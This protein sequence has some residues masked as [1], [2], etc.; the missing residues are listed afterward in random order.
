LSQDL[1][2]LLFVL[3]QTNRGYFKKKLINK[4]YDNGKLHEMYCCVFGE[5]FGKNPNVKMG[6]TGGGGLDGV[7][8]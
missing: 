5:F 3:Q 4:E 8:S 2:F 7:E 1:L 6:K